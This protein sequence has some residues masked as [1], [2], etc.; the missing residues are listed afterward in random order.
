MTIW[1]AAVVGMK[2]QHETYN[3]KAASTEDTSKPLLSL[4]PPWDRIFRGENVTLHCEGSSASHSNEIQWLHNGSNIP[5]QTP[6]YSITF[7]T[8]NNSGEYRCRTRD[9]AL[10]DP[11]Y[12]EVYSDCLLLQSS[13]PIMQEGEPLLLHCHGWKNQAVYKVTFYHKNKALKYWYENHN[14]SIRHATVHNRGSYHCTGILWRINYTSEALYI[15]FHAEKGALSHMQF[16]LPLM[17]GIL[18]VVD[19]ALL[20]LTQKQLNFLI[21]KEKILASKDPAKADTEAESKAK[22][23][24]EAAFDPEP[25]PQPQP[26]PE[27]KYEPD[28]DPDL[29][30]DLIPLSL[31]SDVTA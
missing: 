16:L 15:D 21:E 10:S 3:K 2:D 31:K 30:P 24:N 17:M 20:V 8:I 12:L 4:N 7:A 18:F 14:I 19:T 1:P 5:V 11:M 22:S 23:D 6:S 26:E 29:D 28:P 9:S 25:E 13:L 27:P